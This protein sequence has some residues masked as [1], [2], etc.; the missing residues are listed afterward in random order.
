[1]KNL[2]TY[3]AESDALLAAVEARRELKTKIAFLE[4]QLDEHNQVIEEA[5]MQ[6]PDGRI[7]TEDYSIIL[8]VCQGRRSFDFDRAI[9]ALGEAALSPFIKVGKSFTRLNVK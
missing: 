3:R 5:A 4:A 9:S 2:K 7:I 8:E 1:M 6:T